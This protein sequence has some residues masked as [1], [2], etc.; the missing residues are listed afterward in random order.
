MISLATETIISARRSSRRMLT[1][2]AQTVAR[3]RWPSG[4]SI[5]S[6]PNLVHQTLLARE[7]ITLP[8]LR[9]S[10]ATLMTIEFWRRP[11]P[12]V[13]RQWLPSRRT[14]RSTSG[15]S[16]REGQLTYRRMLAIFSWMWLTGPRKRLSR[17]C[18]RPPSSR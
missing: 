9:I 16:L 11:F 5:R 3:I 13:A 18:L 10:S 2:L 12:L 8:R 6:L 14:S 1:W 7:S 4:K 15:T 17:S